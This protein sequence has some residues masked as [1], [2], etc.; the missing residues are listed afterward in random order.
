[1][2]REFRGFTGTKRYVPVR[3]LGAGGMG[4]VY[5]VEDRTHG[6]RVALKVMLADDPG[7]LL[8][9]KQECRVMAELHHPNLVRLFELGQHEGQWFFTMELVHGH[10]LLDVLLH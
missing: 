7:R 8:R 1:M 3:L 4:A 5:E 9:F 10:A 6:G 2:P